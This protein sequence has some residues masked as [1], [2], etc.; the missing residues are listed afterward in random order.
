MPYKI[1]DKALGACLGFIKCV[2][3]GRER[4]EEGQSHGC[5]ILLRLDKNV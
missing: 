2:G 3:M 5:F 4:P 1:P